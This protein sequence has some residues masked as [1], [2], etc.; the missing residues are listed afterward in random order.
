MDVSF[1]VEQVTTEAV[2]FDTD[3]PYEVNNLQM[4][5]SLGEGSLGKVHLGQDLETKT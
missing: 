5:K 3:Y 1:Q 4:T 2:I